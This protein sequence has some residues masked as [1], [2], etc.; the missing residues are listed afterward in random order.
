MKNNKDFARLIQAYA[1]GRGYCGS[2][3]DGQV[4]NVTDFIP[5]TGEV[6]ADQFVTW[7][8]TAEGLHPEYGGPRKE[9]I[10]IFIKHMG[11]NSVDA[12]RLQY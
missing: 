3:V 1:V 4:Q 5:E 11:T 2:I 12:S 8:L 9:L 7:L 10:R 6:T